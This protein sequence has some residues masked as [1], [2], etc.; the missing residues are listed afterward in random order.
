MRRERR[1]GSGKK[2]KVETCELGLEEEIW[3]GLQRDAFKERVVKR[4]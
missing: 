1:E 2:R 3:F 4:E